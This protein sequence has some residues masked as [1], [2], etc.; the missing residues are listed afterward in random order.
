MF[1]KR[2]KEEGVVALFERPTGLI[3]AAQAVRGR[4]WTEFDCFT[5]YPIHG[6][7]HAMDLPRSKIPWVTFCFGL[8]GCFAGF[9]FQY[10]TSVIDWPIIIGGK[11][12]NSWP[13]FIPITFECTILFGG[14]ATVAAL[15][16][17]CRIPNL[18]AKVLD[19]E[20]TNHRFAIFVSKHQ[21][22]FEVTEV[23]KMFAELGA[24]DV[25]VVE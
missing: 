6:L 13:A 3:R 25:K 8:I 9:G 16:F 12:M 18:K 22:G 4:S 10:W 21:K 19:P 23:K 14:L 24:Y 20:L 5:P 17:V 11:P 7:D 15:F 1:S 2:K